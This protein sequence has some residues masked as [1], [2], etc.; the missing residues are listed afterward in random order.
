[1]IATLVAVLEGLPVV[2]YAFWAGGG[3]LLIATVWTSFDLRRRIAEIGI[4]GPWV[5]VRSIADVAARRAEP[6][7][8]VLDVRDYGTWAH[9]TVG[10]TSYEL[11]RADWPHFEELV[12][13]LAASRSGSSDPV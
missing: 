7:R 12:E 5:Q 4:A 10:L 9:L 13:A 1:M 6:A 11:E 8:R 2:P 3:A